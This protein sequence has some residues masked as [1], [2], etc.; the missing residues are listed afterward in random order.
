MEN[1]IKKCPI[2]FTKGAIIEVLSIIEEAGEKN[3]LRI[4]VKSGGCSGLSYILDFQEATETDTIYIVSGFKV[5]I[6]H[7]DLI[8]INN[9]EID[10]EQDLNNRGFIYSNPNAESTCGCGTSFS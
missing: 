4:G 8:H 1:L 3:P 6:D 10:F 9:L 5:A 2:N 7:L